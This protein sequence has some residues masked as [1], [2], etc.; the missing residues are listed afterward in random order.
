DTLVNFFAFWLEMTPVEKQ[1]LLEEAGGEPRA[2]RLVEILEFRLYAA[3]RGDLLRRLD[4]EK[5]RF[6]LGLT[7]SP[8][9]LSRRYPL[10]RRLGVVR[11]LVSPRYA[12]GVAAW[13]EYRADLYDGH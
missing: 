12:D 1:C 6:F 4:A 8:L 11:M 2:R 5:L 7:E 3:Q 13:L 9:Y 10:W